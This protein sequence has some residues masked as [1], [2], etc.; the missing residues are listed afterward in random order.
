MNG[1]V[2]MMSASGRPPEAF[3]ASV[4]GGTFRNAASAKVSRA[5][6]VIAAKEPAK[7]AGASRSRLKAASCG[8]PTAA[9]TPPASTSE[10]AEARLSG[11]VTSPAAKR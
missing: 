7:T 6:T 1:A 4:T 8:P 3:A 5:S 11:S 9:I 10:I 2:F